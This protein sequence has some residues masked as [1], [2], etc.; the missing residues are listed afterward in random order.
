MDPNK[1]TSSSTTKKWLIG[2]GIGCGAVILIVGLLFVAGVFYVK[3]LVEGFKES[4]ALMD[5]LTE[6]Y[7]KVTEFCPE[8][9]GSMKY[10]RL[11]AF[12]QVR[13]SMTPQLD[14]FAESINILSDG[15]WG[16]VEGERESTSTI[17]KISTG[18]GLIPQ[19]ADYYKI[20]NQSL[21]DAEMGIGEYY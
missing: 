12:L 21:L 17:K 11:E 13:D 3:N 9:D 15:E 14:K 1:P 16:G 6:R 19:I 5:T 7:G 20:R 18:I 10:D 4:V 2:C 8:P